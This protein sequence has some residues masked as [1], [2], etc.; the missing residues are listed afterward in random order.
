MSSIS[1]LTR[2]CLKQLN[3][4]AS[5]EALLKHQ[6]E[7]PLRAWKDE[8]GRLR[9]WAGN[10][11]AHQTG[12]SSLE[13]RLRDASHLKDQTVKILGAIESLITDLQ[14]TLSEN[15]EQ[16]EKL[17][18]E[19]IEGLLAELTLE[20]DSNGTMTTQ[21]AYESLVERV[22]LLFDISMAVRR[23]AHHDR[24]IGTE[25]GDA[26]PFK[27]HFRQ[28]VSQKYPKADDLLIGYVS[29]AMARQRAVLK[30]RERH[31][32]KLSQGMPME[33]DGNGTVQLSET[34]ATTFIQEAGRDI[35]TDPTSNSEVSA[36]S[37]A[38]SLLACGERLAIPPLPKEA[39]QQAPFE[40]PY[41]YFIITVKDRHAWARHIFRDLSPYTCVF[42]G[43]SKQSTPYDSRRV[44]YNHIRQMHLAEQN[45][46][47]SYNCPLCAEGPLPNV[48]FERHVG[49]HLEE[50]ALFVL[51]R[52][53][54]EDDVV[55]EEPYD[56]S[57][58]SESVVNTP[59]DHGSQMEPSSSAGLQ[60]SIA[61]TQQPQP[62]V[63]EPHSQSTLETVP[64]RS[65]DEES[66]SS[67]PPAPGGVDLGQWSKFTDSGEDETRAAPTRPINKPM[68]T[69]NPKRISAWASWTM[70]FCVSSPSSLQVSLCLESN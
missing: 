12:Q 30:Y 62:V 52:D 17:L 11:G 18:D 50:L 3:I 39:A 2:G 59:E 34:L 6:N 32:Q 7:V 33:D 51:P 20:D 44:W 42:S 70:Y 31:H 63:L 61:D 40:C 56:G 28:H 64:R 53:V 19:D 27:F 1:D 15:N 13:Y 69:P 38:G 29:S 41:C 58:E 37:Y 43:C 23:P 35:S 54:H 49:R 14:A 36:T 5:S 8:L 22:S 57:Q 66:R 48:S 4:L 68:E 26:E 46:G 47:G 60:G 16:E 9:L 10:I 67:A 21:E 24:L 55:D 25:K 65:N 45:V